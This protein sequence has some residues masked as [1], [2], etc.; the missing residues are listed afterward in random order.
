MSIALIGIIILFIAH[1]VVSFLFYTRVLSDRRFEVKNKFE[2]LEKNQERIEKIVKEEAREI[3]GEQRQVLGSFENS[4]LSRI[5]DNENSQKN[6]SDSFLKQM[7][8]LTI[9]N[10]QKLENIRETVEGRLKSLQDENM[11]K[12]EQMREVVDEKLHDTLDKRLNESFSRVSQHLESVYKGL[13]E[14]QV[15]ASSVGD[16]KQMLTNVKSRGTWGEI[17]LG[18]LLEQILIADQYATNV[19]VKKN[20]NERV[21]FAIK[22]PGRGDNDEMVWLPIDAKFPQEDYQRLVQAQDEANVEG[23][24]RYRKQLEV[25]IKAEAKDIKEKYIDPPNTTDFAVMYLPVEGLFAE[26]LRTSGLFEVVQREFRVIITGPTTLTAVLNSLQMGFRTLAIQKRSSQVWQ[27]LARVKQEFGKFGG[28]LDKTQKKLSE[29][30]NTIE[31]ASKK[32]RTIETQLSK[33]EQ[34]PSGQ[35]VKISDDALDAS[36]DESSDTADDIL[37]SK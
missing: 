9:I 16:L 31:L 37:I 24:E 12:L 29:A 11:K 36:L 7:S 23:V 25:R 18:M 10:E 14:M 27:L 2:Q 30:S 21:E 15:L 28:I 32:S 35:E 3:R 22:L 4:L 13:G 26:V 19:V 6:H 17:Q 1:L 20:T 34:I 8:A 5:K 33:V